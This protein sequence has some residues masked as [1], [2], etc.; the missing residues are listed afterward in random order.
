VVNPLCPWA[1]LFCG[2]F[3]FGL[4]PRFLSGLLFSLDETQI[5]LGDLRVVVVVGPVGFL[6][7]FDLP[8]FMDQLCPCTNVFLTA[9]AHEGPSLRATSA[10]LEE[11]K[12]KELGG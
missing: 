9:Y 2:C 6:V 5:W 10:K 3:L 4:L 7:I 12:P 1:N 8:A 11:K